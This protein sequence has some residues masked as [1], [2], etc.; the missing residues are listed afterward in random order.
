MASLHA[1]P[2]I[3]HSCLAWAVCLRQLPA[4]TH[5]ACAYNSQQ[6]GQLQLTQAQLLRSLD[7]SGRIHSPVVGVTSAPLEDLSKRSF[8]QCIPC[9]GVYMAVAAVIQQA[10]LF[11]L[12]I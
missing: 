4:A 10:S 12:C 2:V 3:G 8:V 7:W 5:T 1:I 11:S 9:V 6:L